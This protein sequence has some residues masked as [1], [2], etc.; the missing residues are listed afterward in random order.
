MEWDGWGGDGDHSFSSYKCS[1][2]CTQI[3]S[4]THYLFIEP[5]EPKNSEG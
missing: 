4:V 3:V 2:S 5:S 1:H